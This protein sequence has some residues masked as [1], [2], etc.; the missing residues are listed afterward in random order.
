MDKEES[1]KKIALGADHAGYELKE[2][3]AD[4]LKKKATRSSISEPIQTSPL[5]IL[6]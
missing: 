6:I 3:I 1:K 2:K 4:Y 5:I